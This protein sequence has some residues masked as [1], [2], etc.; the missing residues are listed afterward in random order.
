MLF[1]SIMLSYCK[2]NLG[3]LASS[4]AKQT[5]GVEKRQDQQSN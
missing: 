5:K 2:R 4:M 1:D 3:F